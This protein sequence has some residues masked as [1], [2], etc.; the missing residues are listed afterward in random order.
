[1]KNILTGFAAVVAVI[2][3]I[4]GLGTLITAA[5][6]NNPDNHVHF[7][8]TW[9]TWVVIVPELAIGLG[10]LLL[11]FWGIGSKIRGEG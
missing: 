8:W 11:I 3:S 10:V 5:S 6:A 1:M 2:W 4:I 7:A 9:V